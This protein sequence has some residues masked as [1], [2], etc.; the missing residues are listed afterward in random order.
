MISVVGTGVKWSHLICGSTKTGTSVINGHVLSSIYGKHDIEPP[1]DIF[2]R[3]LDITFGI[4]AKISFFSKTG[5]NLGSFEFSEHHKSVRGPAPSS[6]T[7][8]SFTSSA[9]EIIDETALPKGVAGFEC[10][11]CS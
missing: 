8:F 6:A 2:Y 9:D 10:M 3:D 4:G 11:N 1:I 5:A 7:S